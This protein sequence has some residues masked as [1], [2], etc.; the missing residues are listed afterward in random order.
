MKRSIY[1]L[2]TIAC[3]LLATTLHTYAGNDS[4][5]G[6]LTELLESYED[7]EGVKFISLKGLLLSFA[8]P[9]LKDT[10][11]KN[12]IDGIESMCIFTMENVS[13]ESLKLFG[14]ETAPLLSGYIKTAE[15]KEDKKESTI[16]L[17]KADDATISDLVVY[18]YDG[19]ISIV[20]VKGD[21]P[22]SDLEEASADI[23]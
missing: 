7:K 9:A 2:A 18:V 5:S 22:V 4:E 23:R 6:S 8:K 14:K 1:R 20:T 12:V 10:P 15:T 19:N 16:Y 17:K 11:L 13:A 21:I 3:I